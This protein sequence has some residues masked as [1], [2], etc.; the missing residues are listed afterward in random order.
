[1][2]G[3]LQG[4]AIASLHFRGGQSRGTNLLWEINGTA[5]DLLVAGA[6]GHVQ[7]LE[8]TLRGGQGKDTALGPLT[9]PDEYRWVPAETPTGFPFNVAQLYIQL[10]S[11]I[12]KGTS[13]SLSF[14]AAVVR[15]RMIEAIQ[16]AAETG[17][18]QSYLSGA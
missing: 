3:T 6:G 17:S 7:M 10:A 13:L 12:Q 15:H 11:D 4:G 18:R 8:L 1:M 5:G 9:I 2:S 14:D 16:T